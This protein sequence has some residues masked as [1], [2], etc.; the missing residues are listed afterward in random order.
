MSNPLTVTEVKYNMNPLITNVKS[1]RDTK[2]RGNVSSMRIGLIIA[3][4][5]P[6]KMEPTIAPHMD[7]SNPGNNAAVRIIAAIFSPHLNIQ[8]CIKSS[9][10]LSYKIAI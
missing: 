9:S 5:T 2:F 1:P 10:F 3:L 8:P 7:N 6:R 4:I